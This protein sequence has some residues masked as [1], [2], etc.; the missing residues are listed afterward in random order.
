MSGQERMRIEPQIRMPC[1]LITVD[2]RRR[3]HEERNRDRDLDDDERVP[4]SLPE[5][6]GS[7]KRSKR[8]G[9]QPAGFVERRR[10]SRRNP[11]DERDHGGPHE[12]DRVDGQIEKRDSRTGAA[13]DPAAKCERGR[14]TCDAPEKREQHRFGQERA[15]DS[16]AAT[17]NRR[18]YGDFVRARGPLRNHQNGHVRARDEQRQKHGNAQYVGKNERHLSADGRASDRRYPHQ[19]FAAVGS[20]LTR[21]LREARSQSR[22]E[23]RIRHVLRP[24]NDRLDGSRLAKSPFVE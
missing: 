13:D 7:G 22:F 6:V 20:Q 2:D 9:V 24:P 5:A 14:D 3:H 17:A 21:E 1:P 10:H 11:R 19:Q 18:P 8:V 4:P 12:D 23:H 15:H 16:P